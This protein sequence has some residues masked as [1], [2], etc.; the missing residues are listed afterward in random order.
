MIS[1]KVG[2]IDR[3]KIQKFKFY[4]KSGMSYIWVGAKFEWN[5]V[6]HSCNMEG[7]V[8]VSG[9][10]RPRPDWPPCRRD[11]TG[12][13]SKRLGKTVSSHM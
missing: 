6:C 9:R 5:Q 4:P 10:S 12:E 3:M 13:L 11:V 2:V 1:S 7:S 8:N